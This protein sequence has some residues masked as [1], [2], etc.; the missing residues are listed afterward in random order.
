MKGPKAPKEHNYVR[1]LHDLWQ[2]GALPREAGL[3]LVDVYHDTWCGIYQ[4]QRC[5]CDPD[6]RLKATMPGCLH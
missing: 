5:N 4:G 6:I 3:H 2:T 1:K